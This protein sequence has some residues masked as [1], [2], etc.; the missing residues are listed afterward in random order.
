MKLK[1]AMQFW[2][3]VQ[4]RFCQESKK[5]I[6]HYLAKYSSWLPNNR[7]CTKSVFWVLKKNRALWNIFRMHDYSGLHDYWW[8]KSSDRL[9]KCCCSKLGHI[10]A[11]VLK[12]MQSKHGR[13]CIFLWK[14][15]FFW[16]QMMVGGGSVEQ[17]HS[18]GAQ[19]PRVSSHF[20]GRVIRRDPF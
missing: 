1:L 6:Y 2:T 17:S 5:A 7:A 20:L 8:V 9:V 15:R 4:K 13:R 14:S 10:T 19:A 3:N 12:E 18:G 11:L 16:V